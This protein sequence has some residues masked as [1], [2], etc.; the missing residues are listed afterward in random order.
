MG[1]LVLR[2]VQGILSSLLQ[3]HISNASNLA[4]SV[5]FKVQ[6]S[7]AYSA[8]GKTRVFANLY[9]VVVVICRSFQILLSLVIAVLARDPSSD[10]LT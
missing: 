9:F 10:F 7:V 2:C 3:T 6:D 1:T 5:A 4:M 8:I